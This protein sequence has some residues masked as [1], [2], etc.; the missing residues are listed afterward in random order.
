MTDNPLYFAMFIFKQSKFCLKT[1]KQTAIFKS[2]K[3]TEWKAFD[4]M[5]IW[6]FVFLKINLLNQISV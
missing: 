2:Q 6:C 1:N 5:N 3:N 4:V